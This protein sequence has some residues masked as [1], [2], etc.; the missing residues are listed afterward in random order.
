M[1]DKTGIYLSGGGAKGSF[2]IGFFKALEELNITKDVVFGVSAGGIL[3]G[4]STYLDSYEMLER[5]KELTLESVLNIDSN[6]LKNLTGL[7]KNLILTK[8]LLLSCTKDGF[9]IDVE[10]IRDLLY[11]LLDGD[12]IKNSNIDFGIYTT[13]IPSFKMKKIFKEDMKVNPLEYILSSMY[14]PIFRPKR[15]IDNKYYIDISSYRK[16]PLEVLKDKNCNNIYIVNTSD[17]N[18]NKLKENINNTFDTNTNVNLINMDNKSSF[19]DF[20]ED[21]TIKNYNY[22][23]EKT[24][25]VLSR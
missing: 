25:R 11:I 19:L 24:M 1:K 7:K 20:S 2:Q 12:K 14:L 15:I 21:I 18:I 13:E 3:A 8:Q 6:K 22:G 4:A 23:Y 16:A 9:L 10:R 5:W 17:I